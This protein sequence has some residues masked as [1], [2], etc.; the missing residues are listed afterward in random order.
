MKASISWAT[1]GWLLALLGVLGPGF[2]RASVVVVSTNVTFE[3]RT[4]MFGSHLGDD[5]LVGKLLM[6]EDVEPENIDGCKPLS[7]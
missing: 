3:D 6:I 5:G 7:Q 4:A 1:C 2:A